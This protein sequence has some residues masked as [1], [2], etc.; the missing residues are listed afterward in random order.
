MTEFSM[1]WYQQIVWYSFIKVSKYVSGYQKVVFVAALL[2]AYVASYIAC[3]IYL[4][5]NTM[6]YQTLCDS[7]YATLAKK[8]SSQYSLAVIID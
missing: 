7:S 1:F 4:N 3:T 2:C 6:E 8:S 5:Q